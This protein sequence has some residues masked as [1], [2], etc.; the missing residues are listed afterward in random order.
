M[1]MADRTDYTMR[2]VASTVDRMA[3]E[4]DITALRSLI[5][6]A[7]SGGFHRA[8]E[9]LYISQSTVSQHIRRLE[10][11]IGRPLVTQNG[12]STRFTAD[13]ELLIGEGR[14]ILALHD[15]TLERLGI[16][17]SPE[18]AWITVGSTEHAADRL[19]PLLT[20][21]LAAQYPGVEIR[22]RLDRGSRLNE[23]V[24]QGTID[25]AVLIGLSPSSGTRPAGHLPL[26][27]FSAPDWIAPPVSEPVPLVAIDDPCTIRRQALDTLARAGRTVSVVGEAAHLAGV[28]HAVRAGVGVALLADVGGGPPGLLRRDDLPDVDPEPLHV[29]ASRAAATNLARYVGEAVRAAVA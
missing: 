1:S 17:E 11:T 20:S 6:I 25:V 8:A 7:D 10:K 29:R 19:L 3:S 27:W 5:A 28:L 23:A 4:L 26:A 21:T 18:Q 14:R 9:A 16:G 24:A 12:R 22:F 2:S 15:E 13:G